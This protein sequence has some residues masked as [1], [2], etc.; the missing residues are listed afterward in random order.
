MP[1][2]V[3]NRVLPLLFVLL[4]LGG[5]SHPLPPIP[6]AAQLVKECDA[7]ISNATS[8]E[9]QPDQW[10]PTI[11]ALAPLSVRA[12]KNYVIITIY[13]KT[14]ENACGYVVCSSVIPQ[15]DHERLSSTS[16]PRICRFDFYP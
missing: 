3:I 15:I 16:Y 1:V 6:D 11:R 13:A 14:G 5:C 8:R 9:V 7:L 2:I 4:L 12:E 10:P